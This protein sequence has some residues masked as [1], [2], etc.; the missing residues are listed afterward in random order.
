MSHRRTRHTEEVDR[1]LFQ[2][3]YTHNNRRSEGARCPSPT[4]NDSYTILVEEV[5]AA[6]KSLE[7]GK[8]AGVDNI[9]SE[10][11]QAGGEAMI[12]MLL[13]ICNKIWQTGEWPTPC[14]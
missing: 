14:T 1:V 11:V 10:L 8:S 7:K 12:D 3:V 13:I 9:P 6:L 2:I 5:E 4:N